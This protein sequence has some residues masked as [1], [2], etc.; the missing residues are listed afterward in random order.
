MLVYTYAF[1]LL[2]LVLFSCY[3][4]QKSLSKSKSL[5]L[6]FLFKSLLRFHLINEVVLNLAL[7]LILI[8]TQKLLNS[9]HFALTNILHCYTSTCSLSLQTT[10]VCGLHMSFFS[11]QRSVFNYY[12]MIFIFSIISD[13]QCSVNFLPYSMVTQLHMYV[14]ILFSHIIMLHCK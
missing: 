13:L 3:L 14:N 12:I 8:P 1:N 6:C 9:I 11:S 7:L 2:S 5:K 10:K 4:S